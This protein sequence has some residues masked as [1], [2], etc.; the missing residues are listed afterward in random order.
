MTSVVKLRF[1]RSADISSAAIA[2]WDLAFKLTR[3][4]IL[5]LGGQSIDRSLTPVSQFVQSSAKKRLRK[6]ESFCV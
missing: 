6:K 3:Q 1:V 4:E 2:L 5:E